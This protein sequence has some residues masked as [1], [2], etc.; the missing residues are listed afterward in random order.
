MDIFN[1]RAFWPM[2][3]VNIVARK[4]VNRIETM[5]RASE[6]LIGAYLP[7]YLLVSFAKS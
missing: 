6:R 5:L 2:R 1:A 4:E 7:R 3:L